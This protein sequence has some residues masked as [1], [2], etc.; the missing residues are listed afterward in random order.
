MFL[1]GLTIPAHAS[2]ADGR[3]FLFNGG[4]PTYSGI[5][6]ANEQFKAAVEANPS[7]PE[8]NFFYALTQIP[9]SCLAYGPNPQAVDT[10][11][12]LLESLG[13]TRNEGAEFL[14]NPYN[15]PVDG[16]YIVFPDN[17]PGGEALREFLTGPFVATIDSAIANL[18]RLLPTFQTFLTATETGMD[19][20]IEVDYSDVL[21]YKSALRFLKSVLLTIGAYNIDVDSKHLAGVF[22]ANIFTLQRDL[23]DAYP[24][25]L[26]LLP[27]TG[28]T[29]D[30]FALLQQ[31]RSAFLGAVDTYIAA[32]ESIRGEADSQ[33]D[34]LIV[35]EPEEYQAEG[36]FRATLVEAK[37]SLLQGQ[38]AAIESSD[39]SHIDHVDLNHL[40]GNND[41]DPLAMRS[42]LP[43][44][45]PDNYIIGGT[46]PD[47]T[48]DG[49]FVDLTTEN[50]LIIFLNQ[51]FHVP[52]T[53]PLQGG[54]M[55]MDGFMN[56]W[57]TISAIWAGYG[58][59]YGL[60]NVEYVKVARDS[61]YIYWMI[62]FQNPPPAGS[63]CNFNLYPADWSSSIYAGINGDGNYT[64]G[65]WDPPDYQTYNETN[66]DY[67]FGEIVE[68]RIPAD[69]FTMRG[70]ISVSASFNYDGDYSY[71]YSSDI[72]TTDTAALNGAVT[73]SSYTEGSIIIKACDSP[74]LQYGKLL[75]SAVIDAQGEYRIDGLPLGVQLYLFAFSD[76]DGDGIKD[77]G[78][79]TGSGGPYTVTGSNTYVPNL[80]LD[81]LASRSL[82]KVSGDLQSA[83]AETPLAEPLLV[84]VT[85]EGG[86]GISGLEIAFSVIEGGGQLSAATAVTNEGGM[87]QTWL[88]LGPQPGQNRVTATAPGVDAPVT[89][90]A[91][92]SEDLAIITGTLSDG[93]VGNYY[94]QLLEAWGGV[95]P[96]FWSLPE[97]SL[98][99]GLN[100]NSSTGLID[101]TAVAANAYNF[102]IQVTDYEG[103]TANKDLSLT[104]LSTKSISGYIKTD[105]TGVTSPIV[106][107]TV[108]L[109]GTAYQAVTN[110]DG[111]FEIFAPDGSYSAVV[112][113][114]NFANYTVTFD[115]SNNVTLSDIQMNVEP[116]QNWDVNGDGK[117]GLADILYYL[118]ILSGVR[119]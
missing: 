99:T 3:A 74:L 58:Y 2:V 15:P 37:E 49:I 23:I 46:F 42:I 47:A 51:R 8:G 72:I 14:E 84:Q 119:E 61:N 113:A 70:N 24:D 12:A 110:A 54:T 31:A 106:G 7:D 76:V 77:L 78:E 48:L 28:V 55:V 117:I 59:S 96:Y 11:R 1:I 114:S 86:S 97:S 90:T 60:D 45:N 108:R 95:T 33:V 118:Q 81:T 27:T 109:E 35:L 26:K 83:P 17:A 9:A 85:D 43:S 5:L 50:K 41:I 63:S 30:G 69:L 19:E 65:I 107:A 116:A 89:F 53:F 56:D 105:V 101:G 62:K 87:A 73:F 94:E 88:T 16:N 32:S 4:N 103:A 67:G 93:Y 39:G 68:G 75:G 57:S 104:I 98:P 36:H 21:L 66:M 6:A 29:V 44:F 102:T 18:D 22:N 34:D 20:T 92:V 80:F 71:T 10:V 91:T 112:T 82:Q 64:L 13:F 38:L 52:L 79:Y 25:F 100:L 115:V 40:F 111:H